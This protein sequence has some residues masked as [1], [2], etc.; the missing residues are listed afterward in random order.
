MGPYMYN[1]F[2]C[3]TENEMKIL[4]TKKRCIKK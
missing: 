4:Q 2:H 3:L 1:L